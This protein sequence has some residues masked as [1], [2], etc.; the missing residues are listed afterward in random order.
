MKL[1]KI[2]CV[3]VLA[4][5]AMPAQAKIVRIDLVGS[6]YYISGAMGAAF[7]YGELVTAS[8]K[9]DTNSPGQTF[10]PGGVLDPALRYYPSAPTTGVVRIGAYTVHLDTARIFVTN[11][12]RAGPS[13]IDRFIYEDN[14]PSA[15]PAAGL[16]IDNIFFNWQ[17]NTA[18][19]LSDLTLP[20]GPAKFARL[21]LPTMA[22]DWGNYLL[23]SNRIAASF[24]SVTVSSAP[25]PATWI[26][27]IGGF[28][29]IGL[30][31]RCGSRNRLGLA[32]P[33]A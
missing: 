26:M 32:T 10:A 21:G 14:T 3:A 16:A 13:T 22:I 28:G 29:L 25:E 31:Q 1:L 8:L 18:T 24:S 27:M 20:D 9:Y 23:A 6:I 5:A 15:P 19:A 4:V 33:K 2:V 7:S 17:D 30:K 12:E 11:G